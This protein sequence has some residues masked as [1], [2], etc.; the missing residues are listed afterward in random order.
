MKTKLYFRIAALVL[1]MSLV[2]SACKKRKAFKE[3]D[4]Q[5]SVDNRDVQAENDLAVKDINDAIGQYNK[6]R[7]KGEQANATTDIC[8][9]TVDTSGLSSGSIR[10]NYNGTTCLNRKR[11]GAIRLTIQDYANGKRWKDVGCVVKV[12]FLNYKVER[13]SD[14]KSIQLDGT[15]SLINETG[16]SWWEFVWLKTQ[17]SLGV[18]S[19]GKGLNVTFDDG[20][21]AS[22]NIHRRVTYTMPGDTLKNLTCRI[23][24]TGSL[25]GLSNL[26]NYGITRDGDEFTSQVK[27]P[28]V[29]TLTCGWWAPVEGEVNIKVES[30]DFT[31]NCLFGVNSAGSSV[32]VGQ[33]D[34]PYGWKV[35]WKYKKR[36][37]NKVVK[38][39]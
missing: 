32:A 37:R 39:Y 28:L 34:C 9:M 14:D 17:S 23:E 18:R 26:E 36:V 6:L 1:A 33:N 8:G 10:L 7:G 12:E 25:N 35:E 4:G 21:T 30:K 24:G 13:T 38:Y 2:F 16:G 11:S 15:Q 19:E 22:Y 20:S 3:E 31:L 27:T 5:T 29:L